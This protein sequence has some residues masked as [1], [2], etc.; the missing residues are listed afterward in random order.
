MDF[1]LG[2]QP[3]RA[4]PQAGLPFLPPAAPARAGSAVRTRLARIRTDARIRHSIKWVSTR[5]FSA[6]NGSATRGLVL[7]KPFAI[8][9]DAS[10]PCDAR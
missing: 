9:S 6:L 1:T 3:R 2:V 5:R 4:E 10:S 8:N 7:P